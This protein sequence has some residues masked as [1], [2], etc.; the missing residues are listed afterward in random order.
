MP[1]GD[2]F[3][4]RADYHE[5]DPGIGPEHLGDGGKQGANALT[6]REPSHEAHADPIVST[7]PLPGAEEVGVQWIGNDGNQPIEAEEGPHPQR[8]VATGARHEFTTVEE[9]FLEHGHLVGIVRHDESARHRG[10]ERERRVQPHRRRAREEHGGAE[11]FCRV[12][13]EVKHVER[14]VYLFQVA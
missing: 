5:L 1:R 3:D 9:P 11:A 14:S 10:E 12:I 2:S 8:E 6:L 4:V 7:R 13:G